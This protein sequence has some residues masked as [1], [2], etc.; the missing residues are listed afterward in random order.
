MLTPIFRK[1]LKDK[2]TMSAGLQ[3]LQSK[4][5]FSLKQRICKLS[6]NQW[7]MQEDLK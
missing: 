7:E 1:Y 6:L 2:H 4:D 3:K 5:L